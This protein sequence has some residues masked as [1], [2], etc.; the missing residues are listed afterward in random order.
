MCKSTLGGLFLYANPHLETCLC[1][2]IYT[3]TLG[4]ACKR[5]IFFCGGDSNHAG[6]RGEGGGDTPV[7]AD[8]FVTDWCTRTIKRRLLFFIRCCMVL[9]GFVLFLYDFAWL[10][11]GFALFLYGFVLFLSGFVWFLY[12][13][14]LLLYGFVW[15]CVVL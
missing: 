14:V 4:S 8:S 5:N 6:E 15:F 10:L 3:W 1:M 12:G 13:F 9:Y 11:Y 2:Q 7:V